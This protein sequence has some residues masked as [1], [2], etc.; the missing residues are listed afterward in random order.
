MH[1]A[2]NGIHILHAGMFSLLCLTHAF[3]FVAVASALHLEVALCCFE[4]SLIKMVTARWTL[5]FSQLTLLIVYSTYNDSLASLPLSFFHSQQPPPEF[6]VHRSQTLKRWCEVARVTAAAAAAAVAVGGRG[7]LNHT[8]ISVTVVLSL[9]STQFPLFSLCLFID[10]CPL[11]IWILCPS[12]SYIIYCP[13]QTLL[14]ALSNI[15][16][17]SP[18]IMNSHVNNSIDLINS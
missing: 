1:Y 15:S 10:F 2:L 12:V 4:H 14:H 7:R 18:R 8:V 11:K 5:K 6:L 13:D 9:S 3:T 17:S 16:T